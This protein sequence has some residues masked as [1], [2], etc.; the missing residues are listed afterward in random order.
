MAILVLSPNIGM[1]GV[2]PEAMDWKIV[3]LTQISFWVSVSEERGLSEPIFQALS[4]PIFQSLF[5]KMKKIIKHCFENLTL[6]N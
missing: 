4:E 5:F 6:A 1:R 2:Y 3:L